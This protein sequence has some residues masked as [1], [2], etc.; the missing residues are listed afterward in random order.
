M[1]LYKQSRKT[2][3]S[4][5]NKTC[6]NNE[7]LICSDTENRT[8]SNDKNTNKIL[9]NLKSEKMRE[10]KRLFQDNKTHS[11]MCASINATNANH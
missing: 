10:K 5:E 8:F 11:P 2:T 7:N 1:K 6:A 3:M 9:T 4:I